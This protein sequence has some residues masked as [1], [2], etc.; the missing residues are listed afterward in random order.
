MSQKNAFILT[1]AVLVAGAMLVATI[2]TGIGT[3]V[4]LIPSAYADANCDNAKLEFNNQNNVRGNPKQCTWYS[5]TEGEQPRSC[6][7]PNNLKDNDEDHFV[8]CI[9]RDT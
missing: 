2:A 8:Y 9:N 4:A 1:A 7:S 3:S 6:N 5:N